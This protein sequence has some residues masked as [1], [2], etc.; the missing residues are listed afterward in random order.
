[1]LR[2]SQDRRMDRSQGNPV[3][4]RK[5]GTRVEGA[6]PPDDARHLARALARATSRIPGLVGS[7][8]DPARR[9]A[10][11]AELLDLIDSDSFAALIA[12]P[13]GEVGLAVFD[14][15]ATLSLVEALTIGRL[16]RT[17]PPARRAT[18]T[19]AQLLS[20]V[21][22]A[23]L[24]EY[25]AQ[26]ANEPGHRAGFCFQR[27]PTDYRLL[28][29]LLEAQRF[30]LILQPLALLGEDLRR[31]GRFLLA[32]P[33]AVAKEKPAVASGRRTPTASRGD[34][35]AQALEAQVMA[36][37]AQLQAVLGRV[38]MPLAEV[39]RLSVGTTMVLPLSNL[40]EVEVE[41]LDG[42]VMGRG[43]LGQFRAMRA[44]RLV[45]V[46]PPAPAGQGFEDA[47]AA[48]QD[49]PKAIANQTDVAAPASP[50]AI[51]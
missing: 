36:A 50:A 39:M 6:A 12:N 30:D 33:Q 34:A 44:L 1:M 2:Q 46:G 7:C 16:S 23:A 41:A 27:F 42:Q 49:L 40:E 13:A 20:D 48:L 28:E 43:R 19:D 14:A 24:A 18:Q 21:I 31:D 10:S 37:P 11:V 22:D 5:L 29:L 51:G 45:T 17:P 9:R 3:L 4:R 15:V 8:A 35:W 38:T 32:L 47:K 26:A 25:D